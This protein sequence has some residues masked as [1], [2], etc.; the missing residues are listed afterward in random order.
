MV[1]EK[2]NLKGLLIKVITGIVVVVIV[3]VLI[4]LVNKPK[5]ISGDWGYGD[6]SSSIFVY[7]FNSDGTG[8][9]SGMKFTYK[10][11]GGKLEILYDGWSTPLEASYEGDILTV[12]DSTGAEVVYKKK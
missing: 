1:E 6:G 8:N 2:E 4:L 3:V 12:V 10:E 9:Y 7:H 5:G 11:D